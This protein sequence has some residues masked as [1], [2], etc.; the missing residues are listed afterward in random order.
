MVVSTA[1]AWVELGKAK[2]ICF[3]IYAARNVYAFYEGWI[4]ASL[5]LNLGV[6]IKYWWKASDG[7]Q[8]IVFWILVLTFSY[9]GMLGAYVK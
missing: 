5:N 9:M 3:F 1:F 4:I 6:L 2:K 8:M 7:V